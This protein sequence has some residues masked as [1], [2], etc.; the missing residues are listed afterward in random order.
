MSIELMTIVWK[1]DVSGARTRLVLL[2]LADSANDE[3]TCWPS[4][5]TIARKAGCSVSVARDAVAKLEA[6]GL[7]ER[8]RRDRKDGGQ[9]S[10]YVHLNR[11]V[12]ES[13]IPPP[14]T[15]RPPAG[16]PAPP[17]AGD[18]AAP[19]PETR[20]ENHKENPQSFDP[21]PNPHEGSLPDESG[22]SPAVDVPVIPKDQ[23]RK[24]GLTNDVLDA[25]F[26]T[27]YAAW[28][29]KVAKGSAQRAYRAARRQHAVTAAELLEA[30]G[31]V[32]ARWDR[33][34]GERTYI[35]YPA[36]WLNGERWA[37]D[38]AESPHLGTGKVAAPHD[39]DAYAARDDLNGSGVAP[40]DQALMD[41]FSTKRWET[42]A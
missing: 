4:T 33:A 19:P 27:W 38:L 39:W 37:D 17:P 34:P 21:S 2:A 10:N 31:P 6:D 24:D 16:N 11:E 14:E 13:R 15:R 12:L 41:K 7:L 26:A 25:E 36:T 20:R 9:G 1:T 35:P 30:V 42:P 40:E 29:K 22:E 28:P 3:G 23:G 8:E 5:A 32:R 18:Q